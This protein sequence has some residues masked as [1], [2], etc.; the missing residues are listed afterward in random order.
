MYTMLVVYA[1]ITGYIVFKIV[2]APY[3]FLIF[4]KV[5]KSYRS[6]GSNW[7]KIIDKNGTRVVKLWIGKNRF[8]PIPKPDVL[9]SRSKFQNVIL[10]VKYAEDDYRYYNFN[11]NIDKYNT[12]KNLLALLPTNKDTAKLVSQI[13]EEINNLKPEV[14]EPIDENFKAFFVQRML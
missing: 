7:G 10:T 5:G 8:V 2:F 11:E 14:I 9:M 6:K 4:E 12:I 3:K 13:N 1:V